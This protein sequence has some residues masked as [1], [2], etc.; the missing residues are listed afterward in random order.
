M[1]LL[2][3]IPTTFLNNGVCLFVENV[4]QYFI[5]LL[6]L[7]FDGGKS[8]SLFH[9]CSHV[10]I[11]NLPSGS[12]NVTIHVTQFLTFS[13]ILQTKFEISYLYITRDASIGFFYCISF[14][15]SCKSD[16]LQA[17]LIL[18]VVLL[19]KSTLAHIKDHQ[20]W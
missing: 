20:L 15:T 1:C 16:F 10:N 18:A 2:S 4:N 8:S 12:Q 11:W 13:R 9:P 5:F 7:S 6:V 19:R 14:V 3:H 17:A